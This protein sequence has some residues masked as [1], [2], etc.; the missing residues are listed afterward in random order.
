MEVKQYRQAQ[1]P[2]VNLDPER[3]WRQ[4]QFAL[5][6]AALMMGHHFAISAV[7]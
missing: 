5:M 1:A 7:W 6:L 2:R 3:S 4:A